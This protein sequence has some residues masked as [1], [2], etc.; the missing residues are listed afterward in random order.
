MLIEGTYRYDYYGFP[1]HYYN[2]K[3]PH[4]GSPDVAE[5]VLGLLRS[6]NI[7]AEGVRRG[8]DHGVFIPFLVAFDPEHNSLNVPIVQVSL[9]DSDSGSQHLALGAALAPLREEGVAIICS[10]M[11]VHNLRDYGAVAMGRKATLPDGTMPYTNSFDQ[12]LKVAA[13]SEAGN[14]RAKAMENL[15]EGR[16]VRQAHPSLEHLLP[17]F[18][19][20]GAAGEDTGKRVWTL[21]EGSMSW[22][23]YRFGEVSG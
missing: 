2:L 9:F 5:K 1:S 17:V 20:A 6:S 7:K 11:A 13:E 8:L 19:A 22:A 10:G 4:R 15:L 16:L 3:F 12:A 14:V 18:V 21:G 23:M